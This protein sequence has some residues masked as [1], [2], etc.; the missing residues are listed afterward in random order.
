MCKAFLYEINFSLL[1]YLVLYYTQNAVQIFSVRR[2]VCYA[3]EIA[4]RISFIQVY[5]KILPF[6]TMVIFFWQ[7]INFPRIILAYIHQS[8]P[9]PIGYTLPGLAF[10]VINGI[11]KLGF[12]FCDV[13]KNRPYP[14][15][16]ARCCFRAKIHPT[17]SLLKKP[18]S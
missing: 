16:T 10:F 1:L 2:F 11:N 7:R 8:F 3:V 14:T 6:S 9:V 5:S 18:L 15:G 4:Y 13:P 17:T 12:L